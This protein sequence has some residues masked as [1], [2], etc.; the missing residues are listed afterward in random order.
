MNILIIPTWYPTEKNRILG[1][2]IKNQVDVIARK[3]TVIVLYPEPGNLMDVL[4]KPDLLRIQD[5]LFIIRPKYTLFP[6]L[7]MISYLYS[8]LKGFRRIR[9]SYK[10]DLIHSHVVM[11]GGFGGALLS[12]LYKIPFVL[13]EHSSQACDIAKHKIYKKLYI[14]AVKKAHRFICVS[15]FLTNEIERNFEKVE[16]SIIHN[17]IN[18]DL[19]NLTGISETEKP[20]QI[21][22]VGGLHNDIKNLPLLLEVLSDIKNESQI[23]FNVQVIGDGKLKSDYQLLAEK[24]GLGDTVKFRGNLLPENLA[25]TL[26]G[27]SFFVSTSKKETFGIAPVEALACG[28]PVIV[29]RCGGP[30][31][32]FKD[33]CGIMIQPDNKDE[34]KSA[35]LKLMTTFP[36]YDP[37][38]LHNYIKENFGPEVFLGKIEEIYCSLSE[39]NI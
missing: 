2:F 9:K 25:K 33:F 24:L 27:S 14:W 3:H 37:E 12:K 5:N 22:F 4:K 15:R 7:G 11:Q 36:T 23:G 1:I 18:T 6:K 32:Y 34:L 19:F 13:T 20:V 29:S 38:N 31:E 16:T 21:I 26:K 28:K 30:E 35:V 10:I 8:V 17:V 39:K